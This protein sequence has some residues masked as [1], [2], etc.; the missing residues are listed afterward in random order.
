MGF[1]QIEQNKMTSLINM[2][3]YQ[4]EHPMLVIRPNQLLFRLGR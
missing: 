2:P 3:F 1:N 4:I